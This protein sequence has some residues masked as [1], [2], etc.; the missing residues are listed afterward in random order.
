MPAN[1][2]AI[3]RVKDVASPHKMHFGDMSVEIKFIYSVRALFEA[4]RMPP[5]TPRTYEHLQGLM[6]SDQVAR[7]Q[8]IA[9]FDTELTA[10]GRA[11]A[12]PSTTR[13]VA[14]DGLHLLAQS[15]WRP[16]SQKEPSHAISTL[17]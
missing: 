7:D 13:R 4:A 1:D 2:F 9:N 5:P 15:N 12:T 17:C 8:F 6:Q 14:S 3:I 11:F 10:G 16:A